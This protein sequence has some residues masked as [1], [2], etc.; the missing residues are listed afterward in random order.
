MEKRI[1]IFKCTSTIDL[2]QGLDLYNKV[3]S[4][5][6]IIADKYG[7]VF[8]KTNG[9]WWSRSGTAKN[10]ERNIKKYL[11]LDNYPE[12]KLAQMA[13]YDVPEGAEWWNHIT[14]T[15]GFYI[16]DSILEGEYYIFIVLPYLLDDDHILRLWNLFS[17]LYNTNYMVHFVMDSEKDVEI[18]MEGI[19]VLKSLKPV[20]EFYTPEE[21]E[22]V[23][24]LHDLQVYGKCDL[25]DAFPL[26]IATQD[27][28]IKEQS[29]K[30]K[31]ELD[32]GTYFYSK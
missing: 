1:Y 31:I 23:Y 2:C 9:K 16:S 10:L 21:L 19:P 29:Y 27:C 25:G 32:S 11:L 3:C 6:K 18:S 15:N 28:S 8:H 30:N 4:I 22:I 7:L 13:I 12:S 17:S 26:C 20:E 5:I 24:K 14:R